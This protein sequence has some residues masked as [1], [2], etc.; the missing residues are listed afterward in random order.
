MRSVF[1]N[2]LMEWSSLRWRALGFCFVR[3]GGIASPKFGLGRETVLD[4][5]PACKGGICKPR[6]LNDEFPAEFHSSGP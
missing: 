2:S 6:A 5:D 3:L 4:P 1:S